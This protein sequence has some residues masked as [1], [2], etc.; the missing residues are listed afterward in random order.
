M[1]ETLQA[2]DPAELIDRL[3]MDEDGSVRA[4]AIDRIGVKMTEIKRALDAGVSPADYDA[5]NKALVALE[6]AKLVITIAW[7][8]YRKATAG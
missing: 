3:Q 2:V 6:H 5:L 1:S 4:A 8:K 7:A